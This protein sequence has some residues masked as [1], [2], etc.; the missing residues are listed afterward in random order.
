MAEEL[1]EW[2]G[3]GF[4]SAIVLRYGTPV[5]RWCS[6]ALLRSFLHNI[7]Q[8]EPIDLGPDRET[9]FNPIPV[10]DLVRLTLLATELDGVRV[11]NVGGIETLSFEEMARLIGAALGRD[12]LF[13]ERSPSP[14]AVLHRM[15]RSERIRTTVGYTGD[16]PVS[17]AVVELAHWWTH[18]L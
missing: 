3:S 6:N 7:T 4:Q 14:S 17:E 8:G 2:Y 18:E 10:S 1:V 16:R 12:A 13:V 11:F 5:G 9:L 15:M